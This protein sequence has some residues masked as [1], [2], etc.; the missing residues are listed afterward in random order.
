MELLF[1]AMTLVAAIFAVVPRAR[2]LDLQLR[3]GFFDWVV[4]AVASLVV[5]YLEFNDFCSARGWVIPRPWP[6][7]ITPQNTTYLVLLVAALIL[8]FRLRFKRLSS[9][10]IKNFRALV[11]QLYWDESYGELFVVLQKN[12]A[13]LFKVASSG[14]RLISVAQSP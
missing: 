12:L 8:A 9:G 4:V 11:E 7:G 3:I 10:K 5:F 1:T 2:Q 6:H 14:F 13:E